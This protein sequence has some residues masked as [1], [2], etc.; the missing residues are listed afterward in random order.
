MISKKYSRE[1]QLKIIDEAK[2]V[3]NITAVARKYEINESSIRNWIAKYK[4]KGNQ[5]LIARVTKLEKILS[6]KNLE[7]AILKELL[8][9]TYQVWTTEDQ[10]QVDLLKTAIK[11]KK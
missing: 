8:K 6:D 2:A 5:D 10:L 3:G 7:N 11:N 1:E 9:K 4:N